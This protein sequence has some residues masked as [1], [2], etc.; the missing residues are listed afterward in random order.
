VYVVS[1]YAAQQL[2]RVL[3]DD[4]AARIDVTGHGVRGGHLLPN[5][6]TLQKH[7]TIA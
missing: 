2:M 6:T 7:I 5:W 4:V 1:A 3:R